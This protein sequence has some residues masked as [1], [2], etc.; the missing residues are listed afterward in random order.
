MVRTGHVV[1]LCA[2]VLLTVGVVMV[3]SADMSVR[4]LQTDADPTASAAVSSVTAES[5]LTSKTSFYLLLAVCAMAVASRLPVRRVADR[6]DRVVWFRPGGDIGVLIFGSALLIGLLSL[7]YVPGIARV[8]NG[9]G[10]WINL[11]LPGLESIQPSEIVK[12]SIIVL[13]A[14]YAARIGSYRENKLRN[15]FTGLM[16]VCLCAGL[17]AGVVVLEDLGTGALM[18]FACGVVLLAAGARW[19]HF[20]MFIPPV[21]GGV[22]LAILAAPYRIRRI[23][24]F[25]DPYAD[26]AGDGYHMIQSIST[27]AGGGVFGRGLGNGLQKFGYLPE[28]TTDFLFAIVSE[29][30]GIV[31]VIIVISA[32][33]GIAWCGTS[34]AIRERSMILKLMVL[35]IVTTISMQALINLFVVTGLGP[36]KGIALPLMSSG[37]TGW[38]MT[39]FAIGLVVSIDRTQRQVAIFGTT[40]HVEEELFALRALRDSEIEL[41]PTLADRAGL[42][43]GLFHPTPLVAMGNQPSSSISANVSMERESSGAVSRDHY[44][45][46]GHNPIEDD[47]MEELLGESS[48]E[49]PSKPRFKLFERVRVRGYSADAVEEIDDSDESEDNERADLFV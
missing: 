17:V 39:A 36:T 15:F 29:E 31:G 2:L 42:L 6:L 28:D 1:M 9:S 48:V 25:M 23:T 26:P 11:H 5:L 12:W 16:P 37:G 41:K 44:S 4:P 8:K 10:R 22:V 7:V 30:L 38:I 27:V 19:I 46:S 49:H 24:A 35:G 32:F 47:E 3:Q 34:I 45:M 33:A 20:G 40:D 13:V 21:L 18:I 43:G 14:W